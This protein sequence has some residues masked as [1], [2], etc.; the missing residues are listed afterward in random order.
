MN[1]TDKNKKQLFVRFIRYQARIWSY[2]FMGIA[3]FM[4][5]RTFML[6]YFFD[7]QTTPLI[8]KDIVILYLLGLAYDLQAIAFILSPLAVL[9]L[10]LIFFARTQLLNL[11]N[12]LGA[13]SL[14][15]AAFICVINFFY[16]QYFSTQIGMNF[17]H[18][19]LGQAD[20]TF[21]YIFESYPIGLLILGIVLF[22]V[23]MTSLLRNVEKNIQKINWN[24]RR[25]V[26]FSCI[27]SSIFLYIFAMRCSFG[28][29]SLYHNG[30]P[31]VASSSLINQ[32][33]ENGAAALYDAY[34]EIITAQSIWSPVNRQE[35][36]NAYN[37]YFDKNIQLEEFGIQHLYSQTSTKQFSKD[38]PKP[39]VVFVQMESFGRHLL[40]YSNP[41]NDMVGKLGLYFNQDF[42]FSNFL[43]S[44]NATY[45]SLGYLTFNTPRPELLSTQ[46]SN[47]LSSSVAKPFKM[48]GY[49]T[50]FLTSGSAHWANTDYFL[51][52]QGFDQIIGLE[53]I[54][55][56][57]PQ[58]ERSPWGVYDEYTFAYAYHL[59]NEMN[60]SHQ[61]VFIYINT[62]TNHPPYSVPTHYQSYPIALP[63]T[64]FQMVS[65]PLGELAQAAQTY[66]Y[67]NDSLG[68]FIDKVDH[69][70][71]GWKTIIGASG[72]HNQRELMFH[73]KDHASSG[74]RF[75]VPFF[76]HVPP[77]YQNN[78]KYD[79][80]RIGSH[81]DIFPTL[82]E[83]ALSEVPYLKLGNNLLSPNKPI[84]EFGYNV[85][86]FLFSE[87]V[88]ISEEN[89]QR[90]YPWVDKS[91]ILVGDGLDLNPSQKEQ[92]NKVRQYELL[93]SWQFNESAKLAKCTGSLAK[94]IF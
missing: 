91:K 29:Y 93:L 19:L 73:Y 7:A 9:S 27:I 85:S 94:G 44:G 16:Y 65:T 31:V 90:F 53:T 77:V 40:L 89:Q 2:I 67:V 78:I 48:A 71:W 13:L 70:H 49:K 46:C 81:K 75:E 56:Q 18:I 23:L 69:S 88:I 87:G 52:T 38:H 54:L 28:G 34:K 3:I 10:F 33:V 4:V 21:A 84:F 72:D 39:N 6:V 35:A 60:E 51:S 11:Y 5:S 20:A 55:K 8:I 30:F 80:E 24:P 42:L 79:P 76:L 86:A 74:L 61:P 36:L 66:Q 12:L 1:T 45:E 37:G 43:S 59:L 22:L 82:Y 58:A 50:I 83:L 32:L 26:K 68:H 41:Q 15:F 63:D 17:F 57:Y 92:L 14:L 64:L 25:F 47:M 62:V